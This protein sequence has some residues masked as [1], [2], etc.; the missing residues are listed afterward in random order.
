MGTILVIA[1]HGMQPNGKFDPGATGFIKKGEHKYYVEDFFPAMK[2]W[3]PEDADVV[4]YSE[5]KVS[6]TGN[7]DELAK[8]Y[9]KDVAVVEMHFDSFHDPKASGGHIIVHDDFKAD[10]LDLKLRDVIAKHIGVRYSHKGDKGVSGRDDLYNPNKAKHHGINYRLVELG[11]GTSRKD[12]DRMINNIE[13]I[14]KDFVKA[15]VGDVKKDVA[16]RDEEKVPEGSYK[17]KRGDTLWGIAKAHKG[18][19]VH[20]LKRWNDLTSNTIYIGQVLKLSQPDRYYTV[21]KGDSLSVIGARLNVQW[22]TIAKLNNIKSPY[23][24]QVG[25]KLKY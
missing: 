10:E 2:K 25:Q 4:F 7:L 18:V 20:D 8:K 22:Q 9:G 5:K 19:D 24:I 14:A 13:A 6:T 16:I 21:K 15:I 23:V 1:G 3:L 12:S 11:F 17:V